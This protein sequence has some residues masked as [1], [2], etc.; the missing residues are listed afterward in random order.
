MWTDKCE[1]A[2]SGLK[3]ALTTELVL[4]A[5]DISR[6]F[7]VQTDASDKGIGAVLSQ[8]GEDGQEHPVAYASRKLQPREKNYATVKECLAIVWALK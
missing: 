2:F 5:P 1:K 4:K 3:S 7:I 8:T 6:P